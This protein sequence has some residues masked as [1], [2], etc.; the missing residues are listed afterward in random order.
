M[1]YLTT[2]SLILA[3]VLCQTSFGAEKTTSK[4]KDSGAR[5]QE[6]AVTA[7]QMRGLMQ[8]AKT[9]A[10]TLLLRVETRMENGKQKIV[11]TATAHTGGQTGPLTAVD[12]LQVRVTQPAQF[13]KDGRRTN[14]IVATGSAESGGA[15][16][17]VVADAF[18]VAQGFEDTKVVVK[19]PGGG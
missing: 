1:K 19:V 16:K 3:I 14:T 2:F 10:P 13:R 12:T 7:R 18:M 8:A 5:V 9:A 6:K 4:A 11:A 17:M 15:L